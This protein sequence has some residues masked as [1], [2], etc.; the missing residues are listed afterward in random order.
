VLDTFIFE[1]MSF[2]NLWS[3]KLRINKK[4]KMRFTSN[5]QG[6]KKAIKMGHI[7]GGI[8]NG[9]HPEKSDNRF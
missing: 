2:F 4:E 7:L 5:R 9:H 3:T 8:F 6:I 1:K